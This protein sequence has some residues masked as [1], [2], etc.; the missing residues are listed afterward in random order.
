M[1]LNTTFFLLAAACVS[2][3]CVDK[4]DLEDTA[5]TDSTDFDEDGYTVGD[6]DC[7]DS[8]PEIQPDA[9]EVCDGVDNDC[10]GVV[11]DGVL[12]TYYVDA[13]VDGFGS[14]AMT[15]DACEAPSGYVLD[16]SDCDDSLAMVHPGADEYCDNLDNDCD[17]SIDEG[18]V[19]ASLWYV[20]IDG[21]GYGN[22]NTTL[23][24]C[25]MPVGYVVDN[26]DCDDAVGSTFPGAAEFDSTTDCMADFDGD[27]WGDMYGQDPIIAGSD[28]NDLDPDEVFFDAECGVC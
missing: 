2:V 14:L 11:D 5:A 10:D 18:A 23:L 28:C 27:G 3:S 4:E 26:T 8:D 12:T 9:I 13:D 15:M 25:A 21:D 7:D 24:S 1:K 17:G 6:G 22:V 20:D 16:S 19:D